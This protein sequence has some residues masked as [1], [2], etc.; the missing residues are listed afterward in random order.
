[1]YMCRCI[2]R[3]Q[4]G[5]AKVWGRVDLWGL[6]YNLGNRSLFYEISLPLA[7]IFLMPVGWAGQ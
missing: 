2:C 1:M 7:W 4:Q 6:E 3:G 5:G